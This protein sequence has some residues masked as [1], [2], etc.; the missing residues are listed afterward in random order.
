MVNNVAL[1]LG[2]VSQFCTNFFYFHD[3]IT[4]NAVVKEKAKFKASCFDLT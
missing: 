2:T 1:R 3:V 4:I